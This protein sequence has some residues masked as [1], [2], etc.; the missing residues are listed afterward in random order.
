MRSTKSVGFTLIE[1]LI[2]VAIIG[3][4]SAVL[5]PNLIR[6][7]QVAMD[8]AALSYA[9]NVYKAAQAYLGEN[10]LVHVIPG[11][12]CMGGASF[13]AYSVPAPSNFLQATNCT[14][15]TGASMVT[16]FYNGGT[17]STQS[18]GQ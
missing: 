8:R 1:L 12:N 11:G 2:V 13:G 10:P 5:V 7:R 15:T 18:V 3:I 17:T 14:Y 16:V 9:Q 6:A 4:L